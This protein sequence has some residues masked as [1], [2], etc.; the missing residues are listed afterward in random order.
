MLAEGG[1]KE[2][3]IFLGWLID[4]RKFI[5][6]LPI[7]KWKAW[8]NSIRQLQ[9]R[10]TVSYQDLA[11]LIGQLNHI[12]FIIPDGRHFMSTTSGGWRPLQ[13]ERNT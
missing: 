11:T 2:V 7:D 5:I 9:Q 6:A 10:R 1:L 8:T 4:M 3:I 13:G 12:C